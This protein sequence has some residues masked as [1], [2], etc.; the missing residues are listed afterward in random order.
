LHTFE[1]VSQLLAGIVIR[2]RDVSKPMFVVVEKVAEFYIHL[3]SFR[4][5]DYDTIDEL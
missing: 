5:T 4:E 2:V 1:E 3:M